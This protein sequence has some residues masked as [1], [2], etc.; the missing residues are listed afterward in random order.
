M[1]LK[2]DEVLEALQQVGVDPVGMIDFA[3]DF[4]ME[5]GEHRQLSFEEFMGMVLDLRGSQTCKV[6]DIMDT[7]RR[8]EKKFRSIDTMLDKLMAQFGLDEE[9]NIPINEPLR[10]TQFPNAIGEAQ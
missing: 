10:G 2:K 6:K 8:F 9:G 3:E 5:D 1:L 7:R 4:F